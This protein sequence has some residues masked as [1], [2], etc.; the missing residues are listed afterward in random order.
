MKPHTRVPG[1]KVM[2]I[3]LTGFKLVLKTRFDDAI[4]MHNKLLDDRSDSE[5]EYH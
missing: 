5:L 2:T 1:A 3:Q 4:S